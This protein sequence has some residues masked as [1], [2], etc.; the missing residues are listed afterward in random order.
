M[1][2]LQLLIVKQGLDRVMQI[3]IQTEAR[4]T[5]RGEWKPWPISSL[6]NQEKFSWQFSLSHDEFGS[7]LGK[8]IGESGGGGVGE[9]ILG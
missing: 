9:R 5:M 6:D 3:K 2:I 8:D 1:G 4:N 7:K